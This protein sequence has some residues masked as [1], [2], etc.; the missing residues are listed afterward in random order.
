MTNQTTTAPAA[1]FDFEAELKAR[2]AKTILRDEPVFKTFW[3]FF[4]TQTGVLRIF[5]DGHSLPMTM[6]QVAAEKAKA[7]ADAERAIADKKQADHDAEV[8]AEAKNEERAELFSA[9]AEIGLSPAEKV[10]ELDAEVAAGNR[11]IEDLTRKLN[12]KCAENNKKS[13]LAARLRQ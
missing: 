3:I 1:D 7:K 2:M 8:R 10:K 5:A 4:R 6:G 12:A 11:E 9:L 13:A